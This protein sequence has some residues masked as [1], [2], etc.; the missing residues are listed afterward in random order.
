M[1]R[2]TNSFFYTLFN[3]LDM[4]KAKIILEVGCGGGT[5][6]IY[7]NA[8]IRKD[9]IYYATDLSENMINTCK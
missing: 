2:I 8:N 4:N 5:G 7:S 1:D 9:A 3:M 6:L